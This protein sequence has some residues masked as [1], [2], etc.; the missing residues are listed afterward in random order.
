MQNIKITDM[1]VVS[2]DSAFLVDDGKTAVLSDT[3]FGFTGGE[4]SRKLKAYLGE[5]ALDYI[6]LTHSHYDHVLGTPHVKRLYPEAK[7][8]AG[9]YADRIFKKPT[10]RAVMRDLD[11]KFANTL[12]V[13]DYE[14]LSDELLVDITVTDGEKLKLGD[15]IFQAVDLPGHTKCSVGFYIKEEKL[16]LATETLGVYFG[17]DTYLPFFLVGYEMS[18]RSFEKARALGAEKIL[19]PHFGLASG[20]EAKRYLDGSE[21]AARKTAETVREMLAAGKGKDEI[22]AHFKNMTYLPHVAPTYPI[23]AFNLNTSIIIDLIE[24]EFGLEN[25]KNRV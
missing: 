2:G 12:G 1:R 10:A 18:L 14:D 23:D 3:G 8:I 19:I 9:E 15:M 4:L 22:L 11:R 17:D 13:G 5:R 6:I 21:S 7:V 25:E 24:R 20:E 16:L